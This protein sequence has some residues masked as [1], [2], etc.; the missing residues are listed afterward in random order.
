MVPDVSYV[1]KICGC[2]IFF[3][4][5]AKVH[6]YQSLLLISIQLTLNDIQNFRIHGKLRVRDILDK[7]QWSHFATIGMLR[8]KQISGLATSASFLRP[9]LSSLL[10]S[11]TGL[12][13]PQFCH[14]L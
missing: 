13:L 6:S 5:R 1:W 4:Y 8:R 10:E 14:I 7:L 3:K 11:T 9:H 2:N 12:V